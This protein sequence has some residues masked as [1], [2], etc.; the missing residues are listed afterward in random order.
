MNIMEDGPSLI[1]GVVCIVL[2][3]SSLAARRL[4]LGYVAKAAFAWIAI[5][6]ALFAIF[7]F[8]F[9]FKAV[10]ERV[11]ADISGTAGQS[12]SGEEITI[13]RQDDGHYWLQV[14]VNGKPVRF[15]IDSGATI[16]AVNGNTARET[17]IEVDA[18]GYPV[19]LSTANGRVTAQ[20]V[21]IQSLKIGTHEIG[22]HNVVVSESFGDTN[23]LGMNFLDSMQSWKVEAN[24]M[25]LKQ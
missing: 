13:R 25:T 14:D 19:F 3:L 2:L 23:V 20:R 18:D 7:S 1:W 12:V 11:R 17:G 8:R 24:V 9:E 6:A 10:W 22:Q 16:T 4:P 15:M 5:F 21:I